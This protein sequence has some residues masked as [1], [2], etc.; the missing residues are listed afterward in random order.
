[1]VAILLVLRE[2]GARDAVLRWGD[3]VLLPI[4]IGIVFLVFGGLMRPLQKKM[5]HS[6]FEANETYRRRLAVN[7][8]MRWLLWLDTEGRDRDA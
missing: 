5:Y 2:N 6:L 1:V 3:V 4:G 7:P 8:V